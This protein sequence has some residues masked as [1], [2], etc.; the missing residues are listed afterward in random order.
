MY[1]VWESEEWLKQYSKPLAST[2]GMST[3]SLFNS[4]LNFLLFP[5]NQ[6]RG[7]RDDSQ[8]PDAQKDEDAMEE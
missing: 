7:E 4:L 6:L 5:G 2:K 1:P 3:H 8:P